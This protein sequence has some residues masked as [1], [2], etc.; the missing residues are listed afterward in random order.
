MMKEYLKFFTY[1]H[2]LGYSI[3]GLL[4]LVSGFKRHKKYIIEIS[5]LFLIIPVSG[6]IIYELIAFRDAEKITIRLLTTLFYTLFVIILT[7]I[8]KKRVMLKAGL[9]VWFLVF[10]FLFLGSIASYT[11]YKDNYMFS[12]KSTVATISQRNKEQEEARNYLH[13]VEIKDLRTEFY[14]D[15][16][17]GQSIMVE[18]EIENTGNRII[19]SL[20]IKIILYGDQKIPIYDEILHLVYEQKPL[21]PNKGI[22]FKL[23]LREK[24]VSW[25]ESAFTYKVKNIKLSGHSLSTDFESSTIN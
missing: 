15:I 21:L 24:P 7:T 3:L 4:I 22:H 25:T 16:D 17:E 18:G 10:E 5:Q 6:M 11:H 9:L 2:L 8:A 20:S 19:N 14:K 1:Y 23:R 12:E 13:N